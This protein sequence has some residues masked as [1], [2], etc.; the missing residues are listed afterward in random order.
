M[1]ESDARESFR[2]GDLPDR[3]LKDATRCLEDFSTVLGWPGE[4]VG[5]GTFVRV[6]GRHGI[7]TAEH[8]WEALKRKRHE[9]PEIMLLIARG[10]NTFTIPLNYLT[11]H[12][13]LERVSDPWGPDLQFLELPATLVSKIKATKSFTEI[14]GRADRRLPLA[15]EE[16]GFGAV[17]G[18]A[19]EKS[20][21]KFFSGG[22]VLL[23]LRGGYV[24]GIENH[25]RRGD[26]DYVETL[27]TP[28]LVP[29][30]PSTYGGVSGSGLWRVALKKR[31]AQPIESAVIREDYVL[32]GV[33]F[34][35]EHLADGNMKIRYHGPETIYQRLPRLVPAASSC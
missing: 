1:S 31:R 20:Q 5:G 13:E 16:E 23:E 22:R 19:A 7:L 2:I 34:Y 29:S 18:F 15:L 25:Q 11:P 17:M 35:E 6:N 28:G 8:V 14:S 10:L 30:L 12:L 3:V 33:A 4:H 32:T 9:H 21:K 27:A 24:S 26:F